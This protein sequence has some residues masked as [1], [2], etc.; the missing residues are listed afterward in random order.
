MVPLFSLICRYNIGESSTQFLVEELDRVKDAVTHM[1]R[2]SDIPMG[3][4]NAHNTCYVNVL[5][6]CLFRL[7]P[8]R[9]QISRFYDCIICRMSARTTKY[10]SVLYNIQRTFAEMSLSNSHFYYPSDLVIA[11][12]IDPHVQCDVHEFFDSLMATIKSSLIEENQEPLVVQLG[13]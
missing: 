4:L 9:K 3:L 7:Q 10:D 8:F 2:D 1:I 6:Q 5:L 12:G 13:C 11:L